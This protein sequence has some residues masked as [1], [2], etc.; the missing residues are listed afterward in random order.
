MWTARARC[1]IL[2]LGESKEPLRGAAPSSRQGQSSLDRFRTYLFTFAN[3]ASVQCH[4]TNIVHGQVGEYAAS[5]MLCIRGN[6][7]KCR[8]EK[9]CFLQ[10]AFFLVFSD[11]KHPAGGVFANLPVGDIRYLALHRHVACKNSQAI[12][13]GRVKRQCLLRGGRAEPPLFLIV[14]FYSWVLFFRI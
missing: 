14:L 9:A 1:R 11:A 12:S 7:K 6:E 2:C 5:R 8:L 13:G 3:N 4:V 10:P